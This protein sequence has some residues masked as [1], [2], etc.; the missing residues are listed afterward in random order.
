LTSAGG[1]NQTFVQIDYNPGLSGL[2]TFSYTYYSNRLD[3]NFDQVS[4]AFTDATP[5]QLES[6][7]KNI[8]DKQDPAT[9]TLLGTLT[10]SNNTATT[11]S[12]P[13]GYS[14]LYIE[15]VINGGGGS[16]TGVTNGFRQT[17]G[18]LPILGAGAAFGF[19]R[20]LRS[21]IKAVR[22]A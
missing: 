11:L 13:P 6:V 18:P 7:T 10:S 8:Y 17:P 21:R 4:L 2:D 15:D 9:R 12:L 16:I 5:G 22:T 1:N 19:S 14:S 20:K 3:V